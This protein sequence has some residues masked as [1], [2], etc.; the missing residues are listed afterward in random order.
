MAGTKPPHPPT[1]TPMLLHSGG[2]GPAVSRTDSGQVGAGEG[3]L[4]PSAAVQNT[5]FH[6]CRPISGSTSIA[7]F[8]FLQPGRF[9]IM[10]PS[11]RFAWE[12]GLPPS[13]PACTAAQVHLLAGPWMIQ[14]AGQERL[15]VRSDPGWFILLKF[16]FSPPIQKHLANHREGSKQ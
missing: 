2:G 15:R 6:C 4:L 3:L 9:P 1:P 16:V 8:A 10:P 7:K 11:T 13:H 5:E 12:M 14:E